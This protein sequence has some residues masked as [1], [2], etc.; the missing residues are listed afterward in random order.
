MKILFINSATKKDRLQ[1]GGRPKGSAR[2]RCP[3]LGILTVTALTPEGYDVKF[4]DEVIE[5]IAYRTGP[6]GPSPA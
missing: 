5:A 3:K 2:S 4:V 6:V 1:P